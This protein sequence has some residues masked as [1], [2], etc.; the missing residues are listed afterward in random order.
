MSGAVLAA[1]LTSTAAVLGSIG[2]LWAVRSNHAKGVREQDMHAEESVHEIRSALIK[3]VREINRDL[4][5]RVEALGTELAAV[6]AQLVGLRGRYSAAL[7]TLRALVRWAR[8][9]REHLPDDATPAPTIP[10]EIRD[11]I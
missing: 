8:D 3:D 10:A 6:K 7:D 1:I 2:S 4:S 11:E 9:I 5:E